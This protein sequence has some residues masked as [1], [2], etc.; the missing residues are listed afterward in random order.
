MRKVAVMI[1]LA[2]VAIVLALRMV[3]AHDE[4]PVLAGAW[5]ELRPPDF[6]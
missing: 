6:G 2:S 5:R 1:A 3:R 4:E